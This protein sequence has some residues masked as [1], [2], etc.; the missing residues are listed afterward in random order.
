MKKL[1]SLSALILIL[2]LYGCINLPEPVEPF[3][4][5]ET[6]EIDGVWSNGVDEFVVLDRTIRYLSLNTP[7]FNRASFTLFPDSTPKQIEIKITNSD[8]QEYN[9]LDF[10]GI[11]EISDGQLIISLSPG[12]ENQPVTIGNNPY[13]IYFNLASVPFNYEL[14]YVDPDTSS[15]ERPCE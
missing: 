5:L 6:S 10:H 1:F 13:T 8:I 3:K 9:G 4:K 11:Y 12:T 7:L 2:S 14:P 15:T